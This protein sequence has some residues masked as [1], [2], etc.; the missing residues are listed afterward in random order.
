MALL[1]TSL[2]FPT[3]EAAAAFMVGFH[4]AASEEIFAG[5]DEQEPCAVNLDVT[6]EDAM[7]VYLRVLES[8]EYLA[9]REAVQAELIAALRGM[10]EWARRVKQANPGPEISLAHAA[11]ARATENP[12]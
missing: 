3:T 8:K 9:A 11:I 4:M 5:I 12:A 2:T 10:L 1:E 6:T 7:D